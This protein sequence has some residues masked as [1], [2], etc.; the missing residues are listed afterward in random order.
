MYMNS[1]DFYMKAHRILHT[2]T[3]VTDKNMNCVIV[4][5]TQQ[6]RYIYNH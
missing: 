1:W 5:I 3:P 6:M 2:G 4:D